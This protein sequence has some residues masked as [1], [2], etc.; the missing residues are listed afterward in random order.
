MIDAGQVEPAADGIEEG[1]RLIRV[2]GD[3]GLSLTQRLSERL[4]A[5]AWRSPLH[6]VRL[7]GR[8][9]LK[10]ITV[11]D[12][13]FLGDV[14]RGR[15]LLD[16]VIAFRGERRPIE[17]LDLAK[18]DWS[19]PFA[20]HLQGFGWLRDLSSVAPRAQAA[21]IAEGI[22][23]R[24]I[25]A[26][27]ERVS[28]TA[29]RP[30]LWGRRIL[31][32][33]AHAPLILSSTDLVY[34]SS[35]LHA[36]ARGAR[37]L[38]RTAERAPLGPPRIAAWSGV[39]AAGLMI[40]G[41]E[42]RR[43]FGERGLARALDTCITP[44]GGVVGRAPVGQ[45]DALMVL[46]QLRAVYAARRLEPPAV[47]ETALAR[48]VPPLLGVCHGDRGLGSWQGGGPVGGDAIDAV[49]AAS[50]VRA[51]PLRQ[52]RDWGYQR[53]TAGS[54]LLVMDGAPPPVARLVD[55][56]CASTLAFE[57]SDGPHR[58][59]V[60][61]G[62]A[63]MANAQ[64]PAALTEGLRTTAAHSTLTLGDLNSTAIQ[65][66]GTL[67]KGV[68]EVELTRSESDTLSRIEAS[69]DGYVRRLGFL[70]RRTLAVGGDGR[71]VRG[72]DSLL[73][74]NTGRGRKSTPAFAVRFHLAPSVEVSPTS[75]GQGA[76]LRL[77]GNL[78]WQFRCKGAPLT[79]DESV[80]LDA[81]GRPHRTEQLVVTGDVPAGGTSVSWWFHRS[82]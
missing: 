81:S 26:H 12:D 76:V 31:A 68:S 33:V 7:R 58:I 32:W 17:V 54:T 13:P 22:T 42:A 5:L 39:V 50:G 40:P 30:E 8:H 25:A 82:R 73:P 72:E 51:R 78:L 57:L 77:P 41:G 10:L 69:H 45:L 18:P 66:D 28:D 14:G 75:D 80:W 61:C 21:P 29:W 19:R 38:D 27:G 15:A 20:D 11:A 52:A 71:D 55:G 79:I 23:R 64:L 65:A 62:G 59:V 3:A 46:V 48:L 60:N 63:R 1:K 74:S 34:R 35:V 56:G 16:G 67:G 49:I 4:Q 36:L 6:N 44:D 53:I 9:P 2:G 24:W 43:Q 47:L 37:H 70:H